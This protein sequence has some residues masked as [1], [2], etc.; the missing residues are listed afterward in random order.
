MFIYSASFVS[1]DE[2][3]VWVNNLRSTFL[4]NSAV[5]YGVNLRTFN[6]QDAN[7]NGIIDFD[8]NEESGTFLNAIDRLDELKNRGVNTIHLLPITPVGTTKALGTAGSL[9]AVSDFKSLNPQ[10]ASDKT[11]LS[12]EYQARKFV[13]EAHRRGISVI[14]DLPSMGS[15]NLYMKRPELF[16]KDKNGEPVIP[17]DW[18]DTRVLDGGS[19]AQINHN[20]FMEYKG[21]VDMVMSIGADGIRADAATSKPAKFWKELISYSRNRDP[22]FM[23]LAEASDS[24]T[25]AVSP[26]AVFTPYDKLLEA[27]F[28]G[29]Y[30]SYFNMK[31]WRTASELMNHIKFTNSLKTK[32]GEPKAVIGSFTTHDELSPVLINGQPYSN[33]ILWLNSTLPVNAYYVDGFDTGDNYIYLWGN[34]K[35]RTTYT[36]DE[37]YIAPVKIPVIVASD[38]SQIP[39]YYKICPAKSIVIDNKQKE[40][41][42]T[43]LEFDL[44]LLFIQNK[45]KCFSREEILDVVWGKDYFGTDRV[46]DD[47]VRRLRKKMPK[48]NV[49]AVYGYGY[50]LS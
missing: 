25:E 9:Y 30:G 12:I 24:W 49:N 2:K 4:N 26:E 36:D 1:A 43:T 10:L 40:I 39:Y 23:W 8:E 37:Y 41:K 5:I 31:D 46:V 16:V 6:A 3:N 44:L 35:A 34:K 15:Y 7:N 32:Y 29:F 47:L 14:V 17:V 18:T 42:L 45:N 22:Q 38:E 48:L 50:R 28:D 33:M 13:T 21:F 27:G 19:E 20:L 11:A